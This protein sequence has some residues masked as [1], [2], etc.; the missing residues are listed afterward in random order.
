MV[1]RRCEHDGDTV[2]F[3]FDKVVEVQWSL[4]QATTTPRDYGTRER[5]SRVAA[6][7]PGH[8]RLELGG[9]LVMSAAIENS[10]LG[11]TLA[12]EVGLVAQE[13][14]TGRCR[15]VCGSYCMVV[16]RWWRARSVKAR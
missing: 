3:H 5:K 15:V 7:W 9:A 6:S 11:F 8:G 4:S 1:A 14:R 12:Q 10:F 13:G 16:L 2:M